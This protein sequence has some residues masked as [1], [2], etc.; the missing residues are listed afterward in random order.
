MPAEVV[1]RLQGEVSKVLND[2]AVKSRREFADSE[3][4]ASTPQAFQAHLDAERARWLKL[5]K[6]TGIAAE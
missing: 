3:I 2:A 5:V 4:V 6:E 1:Q